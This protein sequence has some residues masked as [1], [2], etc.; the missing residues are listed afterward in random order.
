MFKGNVT[1][2]SIKTRSRRERANLNVHRCKVISKN[3]LHNHCLNHCPHIM[4]W[5]DD[6]MYRD[7]ALSESDLESDVESDLESDLDVDVDSD[8]DIDL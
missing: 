6:N 8:V 4:C 7:W 5:C 2:K 3:D 1:D